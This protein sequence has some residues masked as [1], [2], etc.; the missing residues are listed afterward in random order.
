MRKDFYIEVYEHTYGD[1]RKIYKAQVGKKRK[2]WFDNLW[3]VYEYKKG[4]PTL[5]VL[6]SS[7]EYP[8]LEEALASSEIAI[9][10][11]IDKNLK[12]KLVQVR[13]VYP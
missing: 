6:N 10:W 5:M 8:S 1:N 11:Y 2:Y 4:F 7:S 3:Y 12:N 9:Q 13:K